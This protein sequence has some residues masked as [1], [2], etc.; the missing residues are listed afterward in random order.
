M[1][2]MFSVPATAACQLLL[3]PGVCTLHFNPN[4]G[5]RTMDTGQSG[6]VFPLNYWRTCF[7]KYCIL[8]CYIMATTSTKRHILLDNDIK[9]NQSERTLENLEM[10][11]YYFLGS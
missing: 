9:V 6:H 2:G 8:Y 11:G 4:L 5:H 7:Y 10:S 1:C 3:T